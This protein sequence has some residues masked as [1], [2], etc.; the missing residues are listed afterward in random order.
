[1]SEINN[2]VYL[3]VEKLAAEIALLNESLEKARLFIA[4]AIGE[5]VFDAYCDLFALLYIIDVDLVELDLVAQ[6]K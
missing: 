4:R 6:V 5:H 2:K 3:W 1:M